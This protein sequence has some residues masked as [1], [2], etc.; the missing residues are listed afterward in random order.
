MR[1]KRVAR[2]TT[3][4]PERRRWR[5]GGDSDVKRWRAPGADA[6]S[7][8]ARVPEPEKQRQGK[9]QPGREGEHGGQQEMH[10]TDGVYLSLPCRSLYRPSP[11]PLHP[12]R[13]FLSAAVL[14]RHVLQVS[15]QPSRGA[16]LRGDRVSRRVEITS[17]C[18]CRR[19]PVGLPVCRFARALCVWAQ[20][21][22]WELDPRG[23]GG[24]ADRSRVD[25]RATARRTDSSTRRGT[26]LC[27]CDSS[28]SRR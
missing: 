3:R 28:V 1:D 20:L 16:Q 23:H 11:H 14:S 6:A 5:G 15:I 22:R 9:S 24:A 27:C 18:L 4:R 10:G 17:V 12:R 25:P 26:H 7:R 21:D 19:T 13:V 2:L 8:L